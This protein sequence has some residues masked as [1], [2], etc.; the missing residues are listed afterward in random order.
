MSDFLSQQQCDELVNGQTYNGEYVPTDQ[1]LADMAEAWGNDEPEDFFCAN[2]GHVELVGAPSRPTIA[3]AATAISTITTT[4][5]IMRRP[6]PTR[7]RITHTM[8]ILINRN[9]WNDKKRAERLSF[10]IYI[11]STYIHVL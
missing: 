11:I 8:T 10:F 7:I 4:T 9:G 1:D 2:C 5:I 3:S 6:R